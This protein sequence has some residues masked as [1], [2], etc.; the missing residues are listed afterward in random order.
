MIGL[1]AIGGRLF[2]GLVSFVRD[3]EA[4]GI[5]TLALGLIT[6]GA[7]FYRQ[8]EELSWV[9][10]FYFTIVTLTTVGHGDISP[11]TTAGRIFTSVYLLIGIGILV[12]L[13][14]EVAKHLVRTN[15]KDQ[16]PDQPS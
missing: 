10:S 13:V 9:D 6:G 8:V 5:I 15:P 11:Q 16:G 7:F 1:L 12:A 4:R 14:N 3:P 2:R